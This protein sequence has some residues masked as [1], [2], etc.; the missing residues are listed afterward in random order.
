MPKV[1]TLQS[2]GLLM[3][4]LFEV[5]IFFALLMGLF[6]SSGDFL[7]LSEFMSSLF[8]FYILLSAVQTL[9]C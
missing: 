8:L 9:L 6:F 5:L 7:S 4:D 3:I 1:S 2:P